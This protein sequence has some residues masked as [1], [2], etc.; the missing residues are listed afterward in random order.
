VCGKLAVALAFWA[1]Y[2]LTPGVVLADDAVRPSVSMQLDPCV[3][4]EPEPFQR[5][6]AI[7]LGTSIESQVRSGGHAGHTHV[8][9]GCVPSGVELV[10]DD[11]VTRKTMSRVLDVQALDPSS[12]TRLLAL[13]TAEFV[14]ASWIELTV[15]P[16]P[17]VEPVGPRPPPAAREA[18]REVVR[19]KEAAVPG[20]QLGWDFGVAATLTGWTSHSDVIPGAGLRVLHRPVQHFAWA[21]S[22]DFGFQRVDVPEGQVELALFSGAGMLMAGGR[23]GMWEFLGGVGARFGAVRMAGVTQDPSQA[24]QSDFGGFGGPLLT[25]RVLVHAHPNLRIGLEAEAGLTVLPLQL[26]SQDAAGNTSVSLELAGAWISGGL[27]VAGGF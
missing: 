1:L 21:M 26:V 20:A 2:A 25:G 17:S 9:L 18:A 10:V 8:R 12:R 16:E 13:A 22:A 27:I 7:E 15:Q 11:G 23:T 24:G 3:P 4:V 14:V 19:E 6:V 5:I